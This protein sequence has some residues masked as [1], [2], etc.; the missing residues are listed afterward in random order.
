VAA[1]SGGDVLVGG[2]R[3][4]RDLGRRAQDL[5]A[6]AAREAPVE[7]DLEAPAVAAE[8]LV[9]LTPRLRERLPRGVQHARRDA[10]GELVE[11]GVL[12]LGRQA[13]AH[14]AVARRADDDDPERRIVPLEGDVDQ[15]GALGCP[16]EIAPHPLPGGGSRPL[17]LAQRLLQFG[18]VF[19]IA[20]AEETPFS[21]YS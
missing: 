20:H 16:G 11:H 8:V 6:E 13:D 12:V 10:L 5:A 14:E 21:P 17:R 18:V 7:R 3:A 19:S 1:G 2:R 15:A 4:V 9:E